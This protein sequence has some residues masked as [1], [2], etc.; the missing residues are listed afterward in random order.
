MLKGLV[1]LMDSAQ[2]A[3]PQVHGRSFVAYGGHDELVPASAMGVAWAH[4]PADTRRAVYPNGYHLLMRDLDRQ[5]V[6]GDVI[7]W[8]RHPDGALPSGADIA[9]AA[10]ATRYHPG[11]GIQF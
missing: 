3:A 6:I 2:Q 4:L 11:G 9:A 7:A 8:I 1:D 10:W 5:A